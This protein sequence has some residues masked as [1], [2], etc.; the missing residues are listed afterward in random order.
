LDDENVD[1]EKKMM[2]EGH[3][4]GTRAKHY[5][6]RDLEQLR[7]VYRGA[8]PLIQTKFQETAGL[9][10]EN[11]SNNRRLA[12]LEA[13]LDRQRVLEA[14]LTIL[15]DELNRI[16]E[17]SRHTGCAEDSKAAASIATSL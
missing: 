5:T 16:R 10:S 6:E 15:E 8:Y 9:E 3:L 2:I 4:G 7:D 17:S 13:G 12:R 14:K 1:H 11:E